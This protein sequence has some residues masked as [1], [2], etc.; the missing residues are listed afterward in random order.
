MMV[1]SEATPFCKT[2]GLGDVIGALPAALAQRGEQVAVV[3]PGYRINT[4]PG[5]LREVYL[6]FP[7]PLAG[8]FSVDIYETIE[9]RVPFYIVFC[10]PLFDR[11]GIYGDARGDFP[12][13]AL[14]FAVLSRAALG[15]VR[16]LF[17]PDVIH[18]HDWQSAL[19]PVNMRRVFHGDPTFMSSRVLF[20][21]HNL[22]YQGLFPP[23]VL[24]GIGLDP[25][26]LAPDLMGLGGQV[27]FLKGAIHYSDAVS[28]VS[29][30]YAREIQT[31]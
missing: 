8:G 22:G 4:Y 12:D 23:S 25:G 11:D 1:A 21:I 18:C 30:T 13:N 27:N 5:P 31:P 10:P 14:R 29:P 2:G 20:T 9:N 6:R 17:R 15:V 26:V 19:V 28:T 7:V 24:P 3:L 16:H